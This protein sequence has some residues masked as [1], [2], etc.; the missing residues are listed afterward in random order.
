MF[1]QVSVPQVSQVSVS[2][3]SIFRP[4]DESPADRIAID[5][6]ELLCHLAFRPHI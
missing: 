1:P 3:F 2:T 4:I 6:P 5:I